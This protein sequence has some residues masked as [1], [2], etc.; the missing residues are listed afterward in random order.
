MKRERCRK[1]LE[2]KQRIKK[3]KQLENKKKGIMQCD[4]DFQ[5]MVEHEKSKVVN[6][7]SHKIPDLNKI[8]ICVRKR[9]LFHKE[10]VKGEIDIISCVNPAILVHKRK[11][12]VDGTTSI[13]NC[14][15]EFDNTFNQNETSDSLYYSSIQ[16]QIDFLFNGGIVTCFAYGQTGSGKT[17]TMEGVQKL[18]VNDFFA[19]AKIMKEETQKRFTFTV[20][21]YEIYNGKVFDLFDRH[22]EKKVLES[23]DKKIK[24][25]GLK[26][27]Q[28]R[29]AEEMI[30]LIEYGL[31]ERQTKKT[32]C[33]DTSS[34]SHAVG[35]ISI[36]QV[37]KKNQVIADS[38][39]LLLVDLAG[40][41]NA[42]ASQDNSKIRRSEGAEINTSLLSLKE[43]IRA[44]DQGKKHI[45]FRRSKL[46]MVLRDS[47]ISGKKKSHVIM[48]ACISPDGSSSEHTCN[49]LR[50]AERLKMTS[51]DS[52]ATIKKFMK[53]KKNR[54]QP[55]DF[56]YEISEDEIN[57][58]DNVEDEEQV[59]DE[60]I[61]DE[62][63]SEEDQEAN[64]IYSSQG[65]RQ[66]EE[67]DEIDEELEEDNIY[68]E[69]K[70]SNEEDYFECQKE[71]YSSHP[72]SLG[73]N[74]QRIN[75][76]EESKIYHKYLPESYS[77]QMIR[78]E[79]EKEED[80]QNRTQNQI[81]NHFGSSKFQ[82]SY[83]L[84]YSSYYRKAYVGQRYN[85]DEIMEEEPDT[86]V[87]QKYNQKYSNYKPIQEDGYNSNSF[88]N[89]RTMV[90]SG[91]SGSLN[92]KRPPKESKIDYYKDTNPR[93]QPAST[94]GYFHKTDKYL[95]NPNS[96]SH[97]QI[98]RTSYLIDSLKSEEL[99]YTDRREDIKVNF[100][101]N[102]NGK[103]HRDNLKLKY[104]NLV[105]QS[106]YGK[107]MVAS[108]NSYFKQ[109]G[110]ELCST[111]AD[112]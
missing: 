112:S 28:A 23:K 37:N 82:P 34:R 70:Y 93:L 3:R 104:K 110:G 19:G 75:E 49:T 99:G 31:S 7:K 59:E 44:M 56:Y 66:I 17:F 43:C 94:S 10:A 79:H 63:F 80:T 83:N 40:S 85:E 5:L 27:V 13:E 72:D 35:T 2:K 11:L 30:Q 78:M 61:K 74:E 8:N 88:R 69:E 77:K 6:Q 25:P 71:K 73:S 39:K 101:S 52:C 29:T 100:P 98:Y 51:S 14:G 84:D 53:N 41:E 4:V 89:N 103:G 47:F 91:S 26:E 58:E 76:T 95:K 105:S 97:N 57:E 38:G 24:I 12:K 102:S 15:F 109:D 92:Y 86:K 48:I 22:K 33:N 54:T 107:S 45:P 55:I 60:D 96:S 36:K 81:E 9:P 108:Y 87:S 67:L 50:Y 62:Y 65:D 64:P 16:P 106:S 21:Y 20:T 1:L 111:T 32:V 68:E 42:Q 46:T 90:H 18:V